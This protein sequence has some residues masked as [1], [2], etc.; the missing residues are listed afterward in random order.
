MSGI[1]IERLTAMEVDMISIPDAAYVISY[2]FG[3]R[4]CPGAAPGRRE[5]WSLSPL[6]LPIFFFSSG[7]L[8]LDVPFML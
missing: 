6:Y 2:L 4:T 8:L 7:F 1:D 3:S 5:Y